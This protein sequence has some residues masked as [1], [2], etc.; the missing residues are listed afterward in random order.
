MA[1]RVEKRQKTIFC[2]LIKYCSFFVFVYLCST[3][4][5]VFHCCKAF[6]LSS[7]LKTSSFLGSAGSFCSKT[8][9]AFWRGRKWVHLSTDY[10][11][12]PPIRGRCI[13]CA[14]HTTD[15]KHGIITKSSLYLPNADCPCKIYL[16][17][18]HWAWKLHVLSLGLSSFLK[19]T[20]KGNTWL[21]KCP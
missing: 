12:F 4:D 15:R 9:D 16:Q 3:T 18:F 13:N 11:N 20:Q 7:I 2:I 8:F 19:H 14:I 21:S 17:L 10:L 5:S 1:N 6:L